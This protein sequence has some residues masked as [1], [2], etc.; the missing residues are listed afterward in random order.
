MRMI[1]MKI[2]MIVAAIAVLFSITNAGATDDDEL[3][4]LCQSEENFGW[5]LGTETSPN[6]Q[7]GDEGQAADWLGVGT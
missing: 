2:K 5:L 4:I 1:E 6:Q 7:L 3:Q